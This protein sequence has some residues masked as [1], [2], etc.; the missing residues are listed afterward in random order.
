MSRAVHTD[1]PVTDRS[2]NRR[3]GYAFFAP[4][5]GWVIH[6]MIGVAITGRSCNAGAGVAGWQWV[7]LVI[8]TALA[9]VLAVSAGL[10]A[11][12]VFHHWR[13]EGGVLRAEGWDR[14]E[15]LSLFALFM[16]MLLLINIFYFGVMPVVIDSCLRT[17]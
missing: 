8:I 12:R 1:V 9:V 10:I 13:R 4:M 15:F 6:E 11:L 14:V 2:V 7:V 5:T 16:S 17:T 3:L